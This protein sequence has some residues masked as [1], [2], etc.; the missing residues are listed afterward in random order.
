MNIS[1]IKGNFHNLNIKYHF[2]KH[3]LHFLEIINNMNIMTNIR[4]PYIPYKEVAIS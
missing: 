4:T 3:C 2:L 1:C